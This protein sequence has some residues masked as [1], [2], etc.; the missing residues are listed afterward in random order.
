MKCSEDIMYKILDKKIIHQVKSQT[1]VFANICAHENVSLNIIYLQFLPKKSSHLSSI[2]Q[3][4]IF[5][6]LQINII[7]DAS[8]VMSSQLNP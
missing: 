4:K 7:N 2:L 5:S 1:V 6:D 3:K 8:Y